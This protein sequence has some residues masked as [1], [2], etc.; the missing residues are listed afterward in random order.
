MKKFAEHTQI[1]SNEVHYSYLTL[2]RN[3]WW[4]SAGIAGGLFFGLGYLFFQHLLLA[5]FIS[6]I[7]LLFPRLRIKQ[8]I[9]QRKERLKQQFQQALTILSASLTAGRSLES[10][11]TAVLQ[12]LRLLYP[13]VQT[14]IVREFQE[15]VWKLHNGISVEKAFADFSDRADIEDISQFVDV[16]IICKRT[17]GNLA[18]VIRTTAR[19]MSDKFHIQQE[20]QVMISQK[21]FENRALNVV[22]LGMIGLLLISSPDYMAPLYEGTGRLVMLIA[23]ISFVLCFAWS[24]KIMEIEV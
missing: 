3:E 20:I 13:D 9:H 14:D 16:L 2:T 21:K 5:S 15:M 19:I 24:Q 18:E 23:L 11:I 4:G 1:F 7:G 17:G 6:L 12:D 10:S 8:K 22:P